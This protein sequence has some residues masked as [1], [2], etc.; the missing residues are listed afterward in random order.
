M[1]WW[2]HRYRQVTPPNYDQVGTLSYYGLVVIQQLAQFSVPAFLFISGFFIAYAARGNRSTLSLKI[3]RAR[4]TNLLWPYIIWSVAIYISELLESQLLGNNKGYPLI[5]FLRRLAVG[6]VA[7]PYFFVPLLCQF[8]LLSPIIARYGQAKSTLMLVFS[9]LIQLMITGLLYSRFFGIALPD[10]FDT[11]S[12]VFAWFAFY[13]P[14]GT[15]CGFHYK[16][17]IQWLT[18][19]KWEL[20][21]AVVALGVFSI[22]ESEAIYRLT[23]YGEWARGGFKLSTFL[24]AVAFILFFLTLDASSM[25]FTR[26]IDQIGSRSYGIYLLHTKVQDFVAK[27]TYHIVPWLL[28]Q[29]ILYQPVLVVSS[30]GILLLFMA[31]VAKSPA[32]KFYRYL[33]G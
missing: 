17:V 8:Y 13:F 31:G 26:A 16:R 4:I 33:F 15:V 2:V 6:G 25:P 19:L 30:V 14:L 27:I 29:Q 28:S 3:I 21:I 32:R 10:G 11:S 9:A 12:W 7:R 5:E 24:Y 23:Q 1:F 18:R 20:F 22:L